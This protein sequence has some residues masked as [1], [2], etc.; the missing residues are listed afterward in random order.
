MDI[1]T[2]RE[3]NMKKLVTVIVP[4][5][6]VENYLKKCVNSIINQTYENIE[7]ILID[8]GSTDGSGTICD[9]YLAKDNRIKVIHKKNEGLSKARNVGIEIS[10]GDFITF[11][12]SDDYFDTKFI[13]N[14]LKIAVESKADLIISGLKDVFEKQKNIY[15]DESDYYTILSKEE[16]Y[17][18]VL[19]QEEIDVSANAK[20]YQKEIFKNIRY[21][22]GELYED[23]KIIDKIIENANKIVYTKYKGYFYL[24][25]NGSIMH[26]KIN[27]EKFVL[28][29]TMER[30]LEF[31]E[32]KY[33]KYLPEFDRQMKKTKGH[34]FNMFIMKR[35]AVDEYC[36]W[37]FD[38]LFELEKRLDISNYSL[39][40]S[41]VFGYVS[42]RLLDVW[43]Y[44][45]GYSY[46]EM[47]V[48]FME[49]Q[50]FIK[51]I[52]KFMLRKFNIKCE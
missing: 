39:K 49:N 38:I 16:T 35:Y 24:Q 52:T 13:E 33:P 42:E 8:D 10:N 30:L 50:H 43:L 26:S 46:T 21:P 31:I 40:D 11:I 36:E 45:K 25:R 32:E 7:I 14:M 5:Y 23:I 12:D 22:V 6:N 1:L 48:L 41:R 34:K 20:L 44:T 9:E 37:L 19:L 2:G 51:K 18:K 47:P 28:L 29:K 15:A 17:R 3:N 27:K 4:I